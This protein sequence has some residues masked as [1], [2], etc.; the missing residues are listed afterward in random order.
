MWWMKTAV[1]CS[2]GVE[3]ELVIREADSKKPA[4]L[5]C[6]YYRDAEATDRVWYNDTYHTGDM[7]YRDE[8]GFL[9]F[10]GR[11]DDVI[12]AFRLQDQPV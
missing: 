5:F 8:H 3:G 1:P 7:V 12:K 2:A 10:V 6:G 11:N 9:W 4:G